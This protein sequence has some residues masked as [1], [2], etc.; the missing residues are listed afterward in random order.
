MIK[1]VGEIV[2]IWLVVMAVASVIMQPDI[3]LQLITAILAVPLS[4]Y[5]S[6]RYI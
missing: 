6:K 2:I 3:I 5:I 1:S 4:I